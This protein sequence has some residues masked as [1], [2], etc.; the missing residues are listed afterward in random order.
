MFPHL[1]TSWDGCIFPGK[2]WNGGPGQPVKLIW[3]CSPWAL[4]AAYSKRH[5]TP[6][7]WSRQT[8]LSVHKISLAGELLMERLRMR[9]ELFLKWS[10][11]LLLMVFLWFTAVSQI[12]LN[13]SLE[14]LS[15]QKSEVRL[16]MSSWSWQGFILCCIS[17]WGH[18]SRVDSSW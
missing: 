14:S 10:S 7:T 6:K 9:G 4:P 13:V 18:F 12:S 16:R 1:T 3:A 15:S 8:V 5:K 11:A 2:V 17:A